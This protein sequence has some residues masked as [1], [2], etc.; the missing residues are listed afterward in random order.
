MLMLWV[1]VPRGPPP[2]QAEQR[3]Q[4]RVV[5][6]GL[7]R[8]HRA[9]RAFRGELLGEFQR[10]AGDDVDGTGGAAVLQLGLRGLVHFHRADQFRWQQRVADAAADVVA[11]AEHEPVGRADGMAVDQG[12]GQARAGI[13][14]D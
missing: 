5:R 4:L 2:R 12:L 1:R 7:V 9:D 10:L 13:R 8:A 6:L 3:R 11:L 14:Q